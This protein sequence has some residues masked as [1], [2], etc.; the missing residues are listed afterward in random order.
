M[1]FT[2]R[3]AILRVEIAPL[4]FSLRNSSIKNDPIPPVPMMRKFVWVDI[5]RS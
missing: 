4:S 2:E 3:E 5:L 1:N